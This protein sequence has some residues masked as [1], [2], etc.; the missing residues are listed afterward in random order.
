MALRTIARLI[1]LLFF[2]HCHRIDGAA[3]Y[4]VP[5]YNNPRSSQHTCMHVREESR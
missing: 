3:G 5:W 4:I 1:M 2:V